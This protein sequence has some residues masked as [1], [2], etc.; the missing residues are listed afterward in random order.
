MTTETRKHLF[1]AEVEDLMSRAKAR[2][3]HRARD[4]LMIL[5]AFRHGLRNSELTSLKWTDLD[6]EGGTLQVHRLKHSKDSQH[7]LQGDEVRQ[8]RALRRSSRSAFVFTTERGG[9]LSPDSFQ[10]IVK[11]AGAAAGLDPV[12]AHPRA[13]R[14]ACGAMLADHGVATRTLQHWLGHK[15]IMHTVRYTEMSSKGFESI[16]N[17]WRRH[18]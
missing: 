12:L 5:M 11:A 4:A 6:L 1:P 7:T 14:H 8:L 15:N 16:D 9:P 10:R 2:G 3:R 17:V 18:K 13:L